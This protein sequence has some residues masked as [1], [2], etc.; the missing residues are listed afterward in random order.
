MQIRRIRMLSSFFVL[1]VGFFL[2]MGV[3]TEVQSEL[4]ITTIKQEPYAMSKGSQMEGF[5]M[6]LLSEVAKKLG[7]KFKVQLVK[8]AS[9]GRQDEDGNWNGMI[10]EVVRGVST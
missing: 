9:Y 1:S 6:D 2:D 5:C 4:R 8:D 3:C 7:F 10:G